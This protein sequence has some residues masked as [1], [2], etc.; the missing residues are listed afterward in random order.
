VSEAI[1]KGTQ[2]TVV[3]RTKE[4]SY[5]TKHTLIARQIKMVI[6]DSL[7]NVVQKKE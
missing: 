3:N 5:V 2:Q 7:I 4:E 1:Q 6:E